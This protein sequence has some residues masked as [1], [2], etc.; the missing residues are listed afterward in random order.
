MLIV[1]SRACA[2]THGRN[3]YEYRR[4][5]TLCRSRRAPGAD[6]AV[7]ASQ[8]RIGR[9]DIGAGPHRRLAHGDVGLHGRCPPRPQFAR[10]GIPA[11]KAAWLESLGADNW[12][13]RKPTQL[14]DAAFEQQA[15]ASLKRSG[16]FKLPG[17]AEAR[18]AGTLRILRSGDMPE[19]GYRSFQVVLYKDGAEFGGVGFGTMNNDRWM[20]LRRG[21]TFAVTGSVRGNDYVA[22]WPLA[23]ED[24]GAS[25]D[26]AKAA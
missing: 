14:D 4:S 1:S 13:L 21:G 19:L 20:E 12:A 7:A 5:I 10:A 17:F 15:L 16:T 25:A 11:E 22:T 23:W 18:E 26:E 9:A 3:V 2:E 8:S 6:A 24:E